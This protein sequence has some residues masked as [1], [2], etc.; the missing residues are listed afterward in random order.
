MKAEQYK[1]SQ[2]KVDY[3]FNGSLKELEKL[4]PKKNSVIITDDHVFKAHGPRFKGWNVI[5]LKPGE[6]FK[7]QATADAV[8]ETLIGM[9]ADRST[10]LVGIG[11]G[12]ITDLTGYVAS[13][14]MRGLDFGFVPS[15]LL[16]M[17]DASIGGKNGIDVGEY[18]NMVGVIRQPS[19][20]LYDI[21]LLESLPLEH[22]SD[23]FAEII[24]HACILDAKAFQILQQED[25]AS[26]RKNRELM[27]SLIRRNALLKTRLVQKDE[28]EKGDRKLLNFGH[29][30]GHA[31]ETQYELSHGQAVSLGMVYACRLSEQLKGF[32][33]TEAVRQVLQQ[34]GLLVEAS[35]NMDKVLK[36]LRMDKKRVS[37][38]MNYILLEK[39]GKGVIEPIALRRLE[40][41][42]KKTATK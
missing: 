28:F 16:A 19:F 11:G 25:L 36:I 22:W 4:A 34:Y 6:E 9:Q 2:K 13:V 17:V 8:I 29:T 33:E 30:L 39:I 21:N 40:Q 37:S 20:L 26:L 41:L 31:I 15:S 24:K 23:G 18:K 32:K 27:G 7:I 14:Y 10:K 3:Y 35:F 38:N 42:L 12:V 1:F 5:S